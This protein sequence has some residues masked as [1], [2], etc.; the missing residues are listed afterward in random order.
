MWMPVTYCFGADLNR[1]RK[2]ANSSSRATSRLNPVA[3]SIEVEVIV[4]KPSGIPK[5]KTQDPTSPAFFLQ[6]QTAICV[7]SLIPFPSL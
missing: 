6:P 4:A 5:I 3:P 2:R 1:S 7:F